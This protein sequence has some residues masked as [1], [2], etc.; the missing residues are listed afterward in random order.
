MYGYSII[1]SRETERMNF[2]LLAWGE[3]SKSD[4]DNTIITIKQMVEEKS[5]RCVVRKRTS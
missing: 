2:M 3:V 4:K 5:V 1:I